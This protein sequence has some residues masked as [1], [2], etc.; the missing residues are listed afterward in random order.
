MVVRQFARHKFEALDFRVAVFFGL[1]FLR[2]ATASHAQET[3]DDVAR[4]LRAWRAKIQSLR[5]E[6]QWTCR[7]HL[8]G[9]SEAMRRL[10]EVELQGYFNRNI[11]T[12]KSDGRSRYEYLTFENHQLIQRELLTCD[13]H[14][15]ANA[16][17]GRGPV[18]VKNMTRLEIAPSHLFSGLQGERLFSLQSLLG[19]VTEVIDGKWQLSYPPTPGNPLI[20]LENGR[21][22]VWLDRRYQYLPVRRQFLG[23][24][25]SFGNQITEFQ[26]VDG[27]LWFPLR[28]WNEY[29]DGPHALWE[30]R[31][32]Q[33][34]AE[35]PEADFEPPPPDVGTRVNNQYRQQ[36]DAIQTTVLSPPSPPGA[37]SWSDTMAHWF[38]ILTKGSR[39]L[40]VLL[41]GFCL[42]L[43]VLMARQSRRTHL[44]S[45]S[46]ED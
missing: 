6:E 31:V 10:S 37:N 15:R 22:L 24:K 11:W 28:G 7:E 41:G 36:R 33:L 13:G 44:K 20:A 21:Q 45:K 14:L 4:E 29:S 43:G 30:V 40:Y 12:W 16:E 27:V 2:P 39:A 32:V 1:L 42:L 23:S 18:A 38:A 46:E 9:R 8:Q 19:V 34:N 5:V 17:F 25:S 3:I 26:K 35:F